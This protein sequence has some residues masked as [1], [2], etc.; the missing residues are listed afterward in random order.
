MRSW[1]P[2]L[3]GSRPRRSWPRGSSRRRTGSRRCTGARWWSRRRRYSSYGCYCWLRGRR[4]CFRRWMN[5]RRSASRC[6]SRRWASRDGRWRS[7]RS[8]SGRRR[9]RTSRCGRRWALTR[10][11]GS[12]RLSCSSS[13]PRGLRLRR[14]GLGLLRF[15][16]S[17][18]RGQSQE[19]L[20]HQF[21]VRI[22]DGARMRLLFRD[23]NFGQILDQDFRL[24]LEFPG[25]LVYS[26]LIGICH[27]P[28]FVTI[29][30]VCF[31]TLLTALL[32]DVYFSTFSSEPSV[33]SPPSTEWRGVSSPG[34]SLVSEPSGESKVSTSR[35]LVMSDVSEASP[36]S[37]ESGN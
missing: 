9:W 24:N 7:S 35:T 2:T 32:Y 17:F 5:R 37:G 4:C 19:V 10:W 29:S 16:R 13:R 33:S 15:S 11:L 36:F 23:A 25:E 3:S 8:Y 28:L 27:Q 30:D 26:D 31:T 1:R 6:A 12:S 21:S 18:L 34:S 20:T 14:S 22:I